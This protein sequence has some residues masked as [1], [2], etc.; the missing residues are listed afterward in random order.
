MDIEWAI[1]EA[2]PPLDVKLGLLQWLTGACG[3][4]MWA[5]SIDMSLWIR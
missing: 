1:D 2:L 3:H 4:K 5:E